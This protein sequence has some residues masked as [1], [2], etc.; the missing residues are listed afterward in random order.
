MRTLALSRIALTAAVCAPAAAADGASLA[1]ALDQYEQEQ[2]ITIEVTGT[3]G[4]LAILFVAGDLD[5]VD[6][7]GLGEF[8]LELGA[9]LLQLNLG[10]IPSSGALDATCDIEC[11]SPILESPCFLQ[12]VTI[13]PL[14][15][16]TCVTE[17]V[18]LSG[19]AADCGLCPWNPAPDATLTDVQRD[20]GLSLPGLGALDEFVFTG[21]GRFAEFGDGTA[22]V[23]GVIAAR[24]DAECRLW[25]DLTFEGRINPLDANHPPVGSP[26]LSLFQ[27][28]YESGGGP[29]DPDL[30]HYYGL[31]GGTAWGI[32]GCFE[33]AR[34][35]LFPGASATQVGPG[36]GGLNGD[37]GLY[38]PLAWTVVTQPDNG[39][40]LATA[41]EGDLTLD[42]RACPVGD[43]GPLCVTSANGDGTLYCT[44]GEHAVWFQGLG[45]D[46]RFVGGVGGFYEAP[47]G[48]ATL[49]GEIFNTEV[50]S[51]R[52]CLDILFTGLVEPGDANYPPGNSPKLG[53][54]D[55][56]YTEN[57]GPI[58]TDTY[59]Y[60][61]DVNGV[62]IGKGDFECAVL[63]VE[64]FG[65]AMQ[66]GDGAS[67]KN[68][69]FGLSS[70]FDI[71]VLAQ[72]CVGEPIVA[73]NGDFNMDIVRCR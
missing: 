31:A 40:P 18:D 57:G 42:A 38:A 67:V 69:N 22:K 68:T 66:I 52:M 19:A 24:D 26:V 64:L 17:V 45:D 2:D 5:T 60:Y 4:D 14:D 49:S 73:S 25:I 62:L 29:V 34:I 13:N 53:L 48:T 54:C 70:W 44:G 65:F 28:A 23:S 10:P 39:A 15:G 33:G 7:P 20:W 11:G 12:V 71:D 51:Q 36:A 55:E 50:P 9:D 59:R 61:T 3:P 35:D 58:D 63:A 43:N 16:A 30:W 46:W 1:L 37:F 56:L 47:D 21:G 8:G 6:V 27:T 72:P 32:D 41:G